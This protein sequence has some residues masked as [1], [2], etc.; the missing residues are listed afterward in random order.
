M[1]FAPA[2]FHAGAL[3]RAF[4]VFLFNSKNELLIQKRAQEKITF[5]SY[6]ANTCCS[7]PNYTPEEIENRVGVKRAAIRKLEHELGIPTTTFQPD[8]LKYVSTVLYK[9]ASDANWIEWEVDHILL[10]RRDVPLNVNS[11]EVAEVEF[12]GK[13]QLHEVLQDETRQLSPWFRLIATRLL[14]TWWENLD[15]LLEK[16]S[17]DRQIHDYC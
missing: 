15:T 4:S 11:N 3:H 12:V 9:A 13:E 8:E 7:H 14:P 10:A 5:P 1:C 6:W 2:H 16:D 17:E